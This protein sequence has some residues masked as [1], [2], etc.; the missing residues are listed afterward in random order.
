METEGAQSLMGQQ[1][2]FSVCATPQSFVEKEPQITLTF[3]TTS[4]SIIMQN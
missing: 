2:P 3:K 1:K 4:A